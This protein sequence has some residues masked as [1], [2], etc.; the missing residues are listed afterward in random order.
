MESVLKH[1]RGDNVRALQIAQAWGRQRL[2]GKVKLKPGV[3][4]EQNQLTSARAVEM[5]PGDW[6]DVLRF[7]VSRDS[8]PSAGICAALSSA[9]PPQHMSPHLPSQKRGQTTLR[10]GSSTKVEG[11]KHWPRVVDLISMYVGW[12]F[13]VFEHYLVSGWIQHQLHCTYK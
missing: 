11:V 12:L 6:R 4:R 7:A 9:P 3:T 2:I 13:V 10:T 5:A 1:S 8:S